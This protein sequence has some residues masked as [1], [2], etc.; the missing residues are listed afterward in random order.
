MCGSRATVQACHSTAAPGRYPVPPPTVLRSMPPTRSRP[1]PALAL[2]LALAGSI[3][4]AAAWILVA[5]ATGRQSSWMAVAAALDAALLLRM[6]RFR[7]GIARLACGL[8]ATALAIVLANWGII[9]TEVGRMLGLAP[10]K[11]GRAS[12]RGGG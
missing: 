10:W 2:A 9:A 1:A 11:I 5:Q 4:I 3:G 8:L 7:P 6:G 12:C